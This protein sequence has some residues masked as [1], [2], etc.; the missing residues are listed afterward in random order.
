[1]L[2]GLWRACL[3][4]ERGAEGGEGLGAQRQGAEVAGGAD[5]EAEAAPR[6]VRAQGDAF[7]VESKLSK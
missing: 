7:Q 2:E 6:G 1:M 4:C 3:A 5:R